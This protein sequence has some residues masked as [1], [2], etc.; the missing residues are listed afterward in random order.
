MAD[1]PGQTIRSIS[2]FELLSR[3]S[4][5][6]CYQHW[7]ARDPWAGTTVELSLCLVETADRR[8]D[9]QP[10]QLNPVGCPEVLPLLD[11]GVHEGYAYSV[12]PH[13]QHGVP[14]REICRPDRLLPETGIIAL[15]AKTALA[16]DGL[17]RRHGIHGMLTPASILVHL[18]PNASPATPMLDDSISIRLSEC[19]VNPDF[20]QPPEV[21]GMVA[22]TAANDLYAL[23]AIMFELTAGRLPNNQQLSRKYRQVQKWPPIRSFRNGVSPVLER[24]L[25]KSLAVKPKARY[26]SLVEFAGDLSFAAE[27]AADSDIGVSR[28]GIF[29][30]ARSLE[31]FSNLSDGELWQVVNPSRWLRF[32]ADALVGNAQDTNYLYAIVSGTVAQLERGRIVAH[33][34]PGT[35]FGAHRLVQDDATGISCY[36]SAGTTLLAIPTPAIDQM[37]ASCQLGLHHHLLHQFSTRLRK[38]THRAVSETR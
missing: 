16:L 38:A 23:A 1:A 30:T 22:P 26:R 6:S 19:G 28:Q 37:T 32:E 5:D 24:V 34:G 25:N 21:D 13:L 8:T 4:G 3:L 10:A 18:A 12:V 17:H 2:R 14:L 9:L 27:S 15:L 35:C 7:L 36:A 29:Y 33:L 31:C 11:R 20:Y